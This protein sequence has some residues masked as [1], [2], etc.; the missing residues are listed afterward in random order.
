MP[1]L[2]YLLRDDSYQRQVDGIAY[3]AIRLAYRANQEWD[4]ISTLSA[5]QDWNN[6]LQDYA[7][8][9]DLSEVIDGYFN[10]IYH[11]GRLVGRGGIA[12]FSPIITDPMPSR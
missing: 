8:H 4:R 7:G 1:R 5:E 6:V 9:A 3:R 10:L 2:E 12:E 11:A